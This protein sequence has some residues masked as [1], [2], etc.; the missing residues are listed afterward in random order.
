MEVLSSHLNSL[1]RF[2]SC[3]PSLIITIPDWNF[4]KHFLK[5]VRL[6]QGNDTILLAALDT[7]VWI[8]AGGSAAPASYH[9]NNIQALHSMKDLRWVVTEVNMR[10]SAEI[11]KDPQFYFIRTRTRQRKIHLRL[12]GWLSLLS[13]T[14]LLYTLLPSPDQTIIGLPINPQADSHQ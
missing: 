12:V 1:R 10:E 5:D 2:P 7:V 9:A 13:P 8:A 14:I 6:W 11:G 4:V 3:L